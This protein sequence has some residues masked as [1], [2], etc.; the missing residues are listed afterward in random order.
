MVEKSV[1]RLINQAISF[2]LV[3]F[4][5]PARLPFLCPLVALCGYALFFAHFSPSASKK[6]RFWTG[7]LW[8]AGVQLIQ[9]SWMT[10]IDYQG[11]YILL[12]YA[13]LCFC[14]GLQFG[15][16][17]LLFPARLSFFSIFALASLWTLCEWSRVLLSCGFSWNPIGLALSFHHIPLQGAA[18]FGVFGLS[19]WVMVVNLLALKWWREKTKLTALSVCLFCA[20]LPYFFG[21]WHSDYQDKRAGKHPAEMSVAL[22]QT[23]LLPS[24][25][26]P[27]LK[28]RERFI[29]PDQQWEKI[30]SYLSQQNKQKWDLIVFPEAALPHSA[31]APRYSFEGAHHLLSKWH[32]ETI[33][34]FYPPLIPPFA[35]KGCVSN[36][37]WAQTL[38]NRYDAEVI[39]G[40]DHCEKAMRQFHNSAFLASPKRE[41]VLRY[42]K[43]VLLPLA[44]YLPFTW[45]HSLTKSYGI[46]DFFTPGTKTQPLGFRIPLSLSICYEE[47]FSEEMRKT[48]HPSSALLINLTNDNYYP[49]SLLAEQHFSHAR[50]RS[51]ENGRPLLRSCNTGV[52]AVVD[53]LGRI[54]G[55][56][57]EKGEEFKRGV[58]DCAFSP[59]R[60]NTLFSLWGDAGIV[61]ISLAILVLYIL[62]I[63]KIKRKKII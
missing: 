5:Q 61:I 36:L 50:L 32:G 16:F 35:E 47:T 30:L 37:F 13:V 1:Y 53:S 56:F 8:F 38:A 29:P 49:Y 2:F 3:A 57:G 15:L 58:L 40:L 6:R 42:D 12:V 39:I 7:A 52:T 22:V 20:L 21:L 51:V 33:R 41:N 23:G 60:Y 10:A 19:F 9:L 54:V 25:K 59:Y 17:S 48:V 24:E 55:R 34:A 26:I 45:L 27:L 44:E 31:E 43:R 28:E 62:F 46:Y 4:G 18:L 14:L 11:Y 63:W